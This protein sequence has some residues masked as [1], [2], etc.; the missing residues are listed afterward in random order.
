MRSLLRRGVYAGKRSRGG[1]AGE[2]CGWADG[3]RPL[4]FV[5]AGLAE[6]LCLAV[7]G[8]IQ[9]LRATGVGKQVRP[10]FFFVF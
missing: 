9:A 2:S 6:E 1:R 3:G 8:R 7:F 5:G 10:S 4:G